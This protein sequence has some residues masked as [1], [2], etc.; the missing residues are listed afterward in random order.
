MAARWKRWAPR[1]AAAVGVAEVEKLQL[2]PVALG[3]E[4]ARVE[5][6]RA[7]Q[8]AWSNRPRNQPPRSKQSSRIGVECSASPSGQPRMS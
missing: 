5:D 7:D 6:Y 8:V 4:A 3:A 2:Q 1:P